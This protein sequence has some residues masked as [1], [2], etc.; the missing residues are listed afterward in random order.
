MAREAVPR[1]AAGSAPEMDAPERAWDTQRAVSSSRAASMMTCGL[2]TWPSCTPK[3]TTSEPRRR[4]AWAQRSSAPWTA[5]RRS[6]P[7]SERGISVSSR[8]LST[9]KV[10][11]VP[12]LSTGSPS[13]SAAATGAASAS[14]CHQSGYPSMRKMRAAAFP[15]Q[16]S[17]EG[18]KYTV[19]VS[20]PSFF[21]AVHCFTWVAE[22]RKATS[23]TPARSSVSAPSSAR[24][25]RSPSRSSAVARRPARARRPVPS[26]PRR[27]RAPGPRRTARRRPAAG[28]AR[29]R[30]ARS[31]G[32][33]SGQHKAGAPRGQRSGD[34]PHRSGDDGECGRKS[35]DQLPVRLDVDRPSRV[36]RRL[37]PHRTRRRGAR[38]FELH[39]R[40]V[41]H[42]P[43]AQHGGGE[44]EAAPDRH[45]EEPVVQA[46]PRSDLL[47]A[48]EAATVRDGEGGHPALLERSAV[49]R[50]ADGDVPP[51][52]QRPQRG[53]R[54]GELAPEHLAAR[55]RDAD[56]VRP[57]AGL[58]DVDEVAGGGLALGVDEVDASDV[59]RPAV[60]LEAGRAGPQVAVEADG[61]AQVAAGAARQDAER[62]P[63][64]DRARR[65]AVTRLLEEPVHDLVDGA[66][67]SHRDH[68]VRTLAKR[69]PGQ[70]AGVHRPFGE[71]VPVLADRRADRGG[72]V[73]EVAPRR[74]VRRAWVD[75]QERLHG[76]CSTAT[77]SQRASTLTTSSAPRAAAQPGLAVTAGA[78]HLSS[79]SRRSSAIAAATAGSVRG[80]RPLAPQQAASAPQRSG[81][82]TSSTAAARSARGAV[83]S[84]RPRASS[85]GS[86]YAA[87]SGSGG[88]SR[89]SGRAARARDR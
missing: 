75:D 69:A 27:C 72:D 82:R 22:A 47:A 56:H 70:V 21:A 83:S 32:A 50:P 8:T 24:S 87:D 34:Q 5:A 25:A 13:S 52:R 55:V 33:A 68:E 44:R 35:P 39:V 10:R 31:G 76:G 60:A 37:Q 14:S 63:G 66:V 45:V 4:A 20:F 42:R 6:F 88:R 80:S 30:R 41:V 46:R 16:R 77:P 71:G 1:E 62:R 74:A 59:D 57:H 54:E 79:S 78:P 43:T 53:E 23:S 9:R 65:L 64:A 67:S 15:A 51:T 86:W 89:T 73:V 38:T 3:L 36:P 11:A 17:P 61:A 12:G 29:R 7:A 2:R 84:E 48:A 85:Q 26:G 49:E 18:W 81:S 28:P 19:K 58:C 40:S